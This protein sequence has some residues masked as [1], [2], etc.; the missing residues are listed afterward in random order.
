MSEINHRAYLNIK[1]IPVKK[2]GES[3][4]DFQARLEYFRKN[5][6]RIAIPGRGM[7]NFGFDNYFTVGNPVMGNFDFQVRK[8]FKDGEETG[9]TSYNPENGGHFSIV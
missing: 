7:V 2:D 1:D 3:E 4:K 5:D 8:K 6:L 9:E